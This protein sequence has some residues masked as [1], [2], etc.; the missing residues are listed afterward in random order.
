MKDKILSL[1][2]QEP[3]LREELKSCDSPEQCYHL[4]SNKISGLTLENFTNGMKQIY[5]SFDNSQKGLL[6]ESDVIALS[7]GGDTITTTTT[8]TTITLAASS[9]AV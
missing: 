9:A 3:K 6:G 2:S 1:L 7:D 8:V 5:N 4:F